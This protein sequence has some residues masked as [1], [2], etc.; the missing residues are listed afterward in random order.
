[1]GQ[2][3]HVEHIDP[4]GGDVIINL[5]LSCSTC[6]L[7]KAEAVTATDPETNQVVPLFNPRTQKWPEHFEWVD[8]GQRVHGISPVGRATVARLK[9]N[10]DRVV[11]AR[12]VWI[13]AGE[14][15]PKL[16]DD[17]GLS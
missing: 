2:A 12:S 14:H 16:P 8:N 9:M 4:H 1:M 13:R 6:N 5:C 15:P 10:L 7:S 11:A 17:Q 3:M